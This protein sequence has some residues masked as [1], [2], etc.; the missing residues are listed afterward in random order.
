MEFITLEKLERELYRI[1]PNN[2]TLY[3]P[4]GY[5][6]L[7]LLMNQSNRED[8]FKTQN[9]DPHIFEELMKIDIE[10][11]AVASHFRVVASFTYNFEIL[12]NSL[13]EKC[14]YSFYN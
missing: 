1:D 6:G 9:T 3:L 2:E 8:E 5:A 11:G 4:G 13:W 10:N 7:Y 12:R 14:K